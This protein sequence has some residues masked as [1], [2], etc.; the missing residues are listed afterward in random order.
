MEP[1]ATSTAVILV[2]GI[3]GTAA[4]AIDAVMSPAAPS[5]KNGFRKV[6]EAT[7]NAQISVLTGYVLVPSGEL[8]PA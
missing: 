6:P 4:A 5:A 3:V 8:R 7:R 1:S 2:S